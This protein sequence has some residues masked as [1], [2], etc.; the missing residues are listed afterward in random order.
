MA[1]RTTLILDEDARR[2]ARELAKR[3]GCSVS[4]AIRRSLIRQRDAEI[5]V[6]TA[7]RRE[8]ALVLRRLCALFA[9]SDPGAEVHRLKAEDAGF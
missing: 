8:R 7:R 3:Y 6:S 4:E 9:G 5:G 2:A 1:T